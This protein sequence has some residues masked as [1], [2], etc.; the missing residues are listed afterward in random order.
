MSQTS[1]NASPAPRLFSL[2]SG[3]ETW[4]TLTHAAGAALAMVGAALLLVKARAA[5][6]AQQA[7]CAVYAASLIAVLLFSTL[8]HLFLH[9]RWRR[10]FRALDQ[11][12][13]YLL[14]AATFTPFAVAA[15]SGAWWGLLAAIWMLALYG[16]WRKVGHG[17]RL[18]RAS[19]ALPLCIG[20]APVLSF[21][22]LAVALPTGAV[23]LITVGG[24]CYSLGVVVLLFD[25]RWRWLHPAWHLFVLAGGGAHY[26]AVYHYAAQ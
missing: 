7:A 17:H 14:I 26:A 3:V 22:R 9:E 23:V 5:S 20:W 10:F 12:C 21:S 24:L 4:N 18:D 1:P 15:F 16:F 2:G 19:V 13:I 11:G 6:P 25:R 8:S